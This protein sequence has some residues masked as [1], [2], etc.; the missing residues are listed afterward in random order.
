MRT[1]SPAFA[2]ANEA[3]AKELRIVIRIIFDVSSIYIT[4]DPN[5]T[6]V[7]GDNMLGHLE[8]ASAV[9][10]EIHPEEGRSTIGSMTFSVVDLES[11][12]TDSLRNQLLA[13]F[14]NL[15]GRTVQMRIGYTSDYDDTVLLF[16][17]QV[18]ACEFDDGVY[19]IT[20]NDIQ[21]E[22]RKQVFE[23]KITNLRQTVSET[24]TIIPVQDTSEFERVNHD[25][26][27]SDAPNVT[28]GYIR[29]E[30]EII[31]WT[32]KNA[33]S[34]RGCTRGVFNTVAVRHEIEDDTPDE[35]QPEVEEVIYLEGP[36]PK[37]ALAIMTGQY[38][39][40]TLPVH[41]QMGIDPELVT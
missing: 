35:R 13:E 26:Y 15:R 11:D 31:R 32:T 6:N 18:R 40:G 12:L 5:M 9:S 3:P 27:Y 8:N 34:F 23:P 38:N 28:V 39:N 30:D 19:R 1:D 21:R 37:L 22:Q 16:T 29:L 17:Q 24:A 2:A 20:C 7:P 25:D 10:Q 33:T 14:Q 4:S 36:G 41:W